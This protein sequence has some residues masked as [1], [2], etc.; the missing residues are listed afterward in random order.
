[1]NE[2]NQLID[3]LFKQFPAFQKVGE[4]AYKPT[5]DNTRALIEHFNIDLEKLTFVHV[6]GT[7]GKG[8]T[9]ALI[10]SFMTESKLKTGLFTSPHINDF[11]E[12]IRIDGKTVEKEF[13]CGFIQRVQ[14][15]SFSF[16]PSFFEISWVMALAYFAKK[17]C[18]IVVVETGLGGRLDATNVI[19]PIL[20]IITNIGLDHTAIL[21]NTLGEIAVEKAG[22]IKGG[23]PVVIGEVQPE[24]IA[25]F[26]E[27]GITEE[28]PVYK[29]D[30]SQAKTTYELN[31]N[32]AQLALR[33]IDHPKVNYSDNLFLSAEENLVKNTGFRGRFQVLNSAPL[34]IVD[35]AHNYDG[36][37][38]L[39]KDINYKF[40]GRNVFVVYGAANDKELNKLIPLFPVDWKYSFTTFSNKRSFTKEELIKIGERTALD[41]SYFNSPSSALDYTQSIVNKQ[42]V[43]LIFGSFFLLEEII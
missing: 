34:T 37:K 25:V 19:T 18:D 31:R 33:V 7:N 13:V 2:Y 12:R 9:S 23:V 40:E 30:Q 20:S 27:K 24:T 10:S 8:T 4:S 1:M 29:T 28:S 11:R 43:I 22:I 42:D 14:A 32:T 26:T 16:A 36:I 15:A 41:I 3:W 5:L 39:I 6:A 21:G 17:K 35:A 38:K